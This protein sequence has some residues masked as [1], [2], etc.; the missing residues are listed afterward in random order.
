MLLVVATGKRKYSW[1]WLWESAPSLVNLMPHSFSDP[2]NLVVTSEITL[3]FE[4]FCLQSMKLAPNVLLR[5]LSNNERFRLLQ[6]INKLRNVTS[7]LV[8]VS[9]SRNIFQ[10]LSLEDWI[11]SQSKIENNCSVLLLWIDDPCVVIGRHQNPWTELYVN[12][13]IEKGVIVS[14]RNSGGGTVFHDHGNLNLSFITNRQDYNRKS[15]LT[16]I[17]SLLR[18]VY[19]INC[20]I[21]SREDLVTQG[22]QLKVSGTASKLSSKNAYHH[23]TLLIDSDLKLMRQTIR[24]QHPRHVISNATSSIR[25]SVVNL[26]ELNNQMTLDSVVENIASAFLGGVYQIDPSE[27]TKDLDKTEKT[28]SSWD[29]IYGRTPKFSIQEKVEDGDLTV[30]VIRG[31]I[32][33]A[34]LISDGIS[35]P[36]D[37]DKVRYTEDWFEKNNKSRK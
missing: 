1:I 20:E 12:K 15:N 10:N 6:D 8:L 28:F 26:K 3:I 35:K 21:S 4:S 25:S 31:C 18:S 16:S 34:V 17:Q 29:W 5:S 11:Y 27:F 2:N 36:I 13:S 9:K 33:S 22:N 30:N 32:D 37:V 23:C 7:K 24:R 19:N 14:R